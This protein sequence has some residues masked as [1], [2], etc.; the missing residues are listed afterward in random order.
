[1]DSKKMLFPLGLVMGVVLSL[2]LFLSWQSILAAWDAPTANPPGNNVEAPVNTSVNAQYKPGVAGG[3]GLD[4]L[5]SD[6][7]QNHFYVDTSKGAQVRIDSDQAVNPDNATF[8]VNNGS[9]SQVFAVDESGIIYSN[10][11]KLINCN[12]DEILIA[13]STS[14]TGVGCSNGLTYGP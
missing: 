9:N 7:A 5:Y 11:T 3:L 14:P 6:T 4:R 12:P 10:G 8:Q 13:S 2:S 1:M